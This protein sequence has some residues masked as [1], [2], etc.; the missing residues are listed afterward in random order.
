MPSTNGYDLKKAV[1]YTRVSTDEQARSG[2]SL[3]QQIEA[4]RDYAAREGYEVMDEVQDPGQSGASLERPGMDR[5]RDLV[6]AGGVSVV[7]AQDRDRFTREPAYH[8][9]L[10]REFEE[11]GTRI[12]ALNDRGDDSPEGELTDGILDQLAKYERA[13]TAERTRRGKLRKAREGNIVNAK[14]TR[15]GFKANAAGTGYEVDE[16]KMWV[17]RRIFRMIGVEKVGVHGVITAFKKEGVPT[18]TGKKVWERAIVKRLVWEDSYKPH[19]F[20]ELEGILNPEILPALDQDK[21]YGVYY[22]NRERVL[23]YQGAEETPRGRVYKKKTKRTQKDKSEWIAIPVPDAGIPREVVD[24]AR[25]ALQQ[26][27][28][29]S[30]AD[31]RVWELSAGIFRCGHCGRAMASH[32]TLYRRKDGERARYHYYRCQRAATHKELCPYRRSYGANKLEER[33]WQAVSQ[34]L[35]CPERL[36]AGLEEMIRREEAASSRDP[37]KQA[38]IW[39]ARIFEANEKRKRYQEM[40]AQGLIGFGELKERLFELDEQKAGAEREISALRDKEKRLEEMRSNKEDFLAGLAAMTPRLIDELPADGRLRV[41]QMLGLRVITRE[42][43][44]LEM[45]GDLT[46]LDFGE[47]GPI[48]T[49][50]TRPAAATRTRTSWAASRWPASPPPKTSPAPSPF[51]PTPRR[52]AS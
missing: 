18:P 1:L 23:T 21:R 15:Y 44:S 31:G 25:R 11:H 8:Y 34:S 46:G 20:E 49:T 5:V 12:R 2:Y 32:A 38:E 14:R 13:K 42:D 37:E 45:T 52:A 47:S 27:K 10:R 50:R 17:V 33:V 26:N 43:G 7:L 40:A 36:G 16:E 28:A 4:L 24:S 6:A 48:S 22:Y 29:S 9:L 39:A 41:Y 51:S 30:R 3:A 35:K 19:S